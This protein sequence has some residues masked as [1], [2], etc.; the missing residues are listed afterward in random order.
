MAAHRSRARRWCTL[1]APSTSSVCGL[2]ILLYY[3][4]YWFF[5]I[6]LASPSC[7]SLD[8]G[9]I[10]FLEECQKLGSYVVVGLHTD[11][12]VN[13]YQGSNHPIMNLHERLLCLLACRVLSSLLASSFYTSTVLFL[14]NQLLTRLRWYRDPHTLGVFTAMFR[15]CKTKFPR[16]P[17]LTRFLLSVL[18][19]FFITNWVS[20]NLSIG[21]IT[22]LN[23]ACELSLSHIC[24]L[25]REKN[26]F[27]VWVAT[28]FNGYFATFPFDILAI[29]IKK[30][31]LFLSYNWINF[32]TLFLFC[33]VCEQR[34]NRCTLRCNSSTSGLS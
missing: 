32:R 28:H 27:A 29:I 33:L 26:V 14:S 16:I 30:Q 19:F 31:L 4:S 3:T 13:A 12:A 5:I 18:E 11:S 25:H 23:L 24:T 7:A 17:K 6:W 1:P 10:A 20:R 2:S 9:H 21:A 15:A 34:C 22:F 8:A